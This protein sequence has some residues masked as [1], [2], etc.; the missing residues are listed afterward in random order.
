MNKRILVIMLCAVALTAA[1]CGSQSENSAAGATQEQDAAADVTES[2]QSENEPVEAVEEI[3]PEEAAA[4]ERRKKAEEAAADRYE[5]EDGWSVS[6]NSELVDLEEGK[7]YVRFTYNGDANATN[8]IEFRYFPFTSTDIVLAEATEDYDR[9]DLERSE[10]YFAGMEDMWCFHTDLVSDGRYSTRGYT[11]VEY[12]EGVLLVERRGSIETDEERGELISDTMSVILDSVRFTDPEPQEEYDYVPGKYMLVQETKEDA[13]ATD[14]AAGSVSADEAAAG[15]PAYVALGKNHM[16]RLGYADPVDIIWYSRDCLIKEDN[17]SGATYYYT[18]EGDSLYL[19]MGEDWI[20]YQKDLG[21]AVN[22]DSVD[23]GEKDVQAFKTYEN[24]NGWYVYYDSRKFTIKESR[25]E[26]D[27]IFGTS[28][29]DSEDAEMLKVRYI[30]YDHTD[31]VLADETRNYEVTEVIQSEGYIGGGKDAW[32]FTVSL[33][34]SGDGTVSAR[35]LTAVEHNEGVLL[36]D[37]PDHSGGDSGEGVGNAFEDIINTFMFTDHDPQEE[38]DYVPG[39]YLL[40]DRKLQKAASNYPAFVRLNKDHSGMFG[41]SEERD[42]IWYSRK[43][44]IVET[45]LDGASYD[46][47]IEG[48]V[49][50]LQMDDEWVEYDKE[51]GDD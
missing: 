31:D 49:L 9:E 28:E 46:Y 12:N 2:A 30:R 43:G 23:P 48:D 36:F 3:T 22:V 4:A 26:V 38:Y 20:E 10:G 8:R 37:R 51:D 5:S 33:P 15:Y 29:E 16:G 7:D 40:N 6:Y 35:K 14:A 39:R 18:I 17:E 24:E 21:A 34:A 45:G 27:F 19:Q 13:E 11:A 44:V 42:I 32:G 41:G 47:H 25:G 50:Y 1:G